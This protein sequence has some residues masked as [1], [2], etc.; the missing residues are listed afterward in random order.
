M[1]EIKYAVLGSGRQG[2]ASAYDLVRFGNASEVQL[3]DI[4]IDAA[5]SGANRVNTLLKSKKTVAKI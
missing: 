5:L 3:L 1:S 2:I 4:N